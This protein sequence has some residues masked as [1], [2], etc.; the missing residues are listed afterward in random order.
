MDVY[1]HRSTL[2]TDLIQVVINGDMYNLA[3]KPA[4]KWGEHRFNCWKEGQE[5]PYSL[6][7]SSKL[8]RDSIVPGYGCSCKGWIYHRK[9]K[10]VLKLAEMIST[11]Q[12]A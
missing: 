9:C 10:H 5:K 6:S 4:D 8:Y 3:R 1:Y 12:A 2:M 11:Q 7:V